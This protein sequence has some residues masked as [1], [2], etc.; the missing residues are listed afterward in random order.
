MTVFYDHPV[1]ETNTSEGK[2]SQTGFWKLK[3]K[4][5]PRSSDPPMAK[6]D[7]Y[8]NLVTAPS[9][10]KEL[11]A[12]TYK[13]RL[14]HRE[15]KAEFQDIFILKNQLWDLRLRN[16]KRKVSHPWTVRHLDKVLKSLK[17]NQSRDPMGMINELFKPGVIENELKLLHLIS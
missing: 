6:R 16:L 12:A 10:L 2:F 1:S 13:H 4:L 17:N 3:S 15:I 11:Y 14:R 5:C 9:Q 8:G 7:E